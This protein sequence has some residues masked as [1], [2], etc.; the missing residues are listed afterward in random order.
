MV[1]VVEE[2]ELEP[3]NEDVSNVIIII[4]FNELSLN[5]RDIKSQT[6]NLICTD[7]DLLYYYVSCACMH[8]KR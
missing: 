1:E 2:Q 5:I 7:L 6:I 4:T 8:S 3:F